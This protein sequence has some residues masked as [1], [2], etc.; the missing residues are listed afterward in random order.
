MNEP[1]PRLPGEVRRFLKQ[2]RVAV[3]ATVRRDG[4]PASTA[5]WY[6]LQDAR[7]L[8]TMYATARRLPNLRST[9]HVAMTVLGEDPY[10]HVSISGPVIEMWDD[11]N[12]EVMDRLAMRYTGEAWPERHPCVSALVQI[13]RWHTYGVLSDASDHSSSA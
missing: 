2:P 12:L 11:P 1:G 7:I 9:P 4:T 6:E 3:L 5:C 8:I 10:Q 13:E